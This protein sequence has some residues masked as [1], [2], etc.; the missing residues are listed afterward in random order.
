MK[1]ITADVK[2]VFGVKVTNY[3]LNVILEAIYNQTNVDLDVTKAE[4]GYDLSLLIDSTGFFD[5]QKFVWMVVGLENVEDKA[6]TLYITSRVCDSFE[7]IE[8]TNWINDLI[9]ITDMFPKLDIN[10]LRWHNVYEVE[11]N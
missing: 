5:G 10:E 11:Y 4:C 9:V 2:K 6:D 1:K 3:N 8:N 7:E